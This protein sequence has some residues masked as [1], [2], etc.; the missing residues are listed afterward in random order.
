MME[1]KLTGDKAEMLNK[2]PQLTRDEAIALHDS[3]GWKRWEPRALGAF[4]L[5][6]DCL[7]V[8]FGEFHKGVEV[9]LGRGVFTH[10][11]ALVKELRLEALGKLPAPDIHGIIG[12]IA[13]IR[14]CK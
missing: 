12:K 2:F 9:L 7:C 3:G 14:G 4:Q 10:E 13:D 11:V 5:F 8:P 6:Q 1:Q